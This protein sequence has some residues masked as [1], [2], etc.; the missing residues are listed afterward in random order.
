MKEKPQFKVGDV[1]TGSDGWMS[2]DVLAVTES[3][4][5]LSVFRFKKANVSA[6]VWV[7]IVA[8]ENVLRKV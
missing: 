6:E 3:Q 5:L 1:L 2:C 4:Y 8:A 7:P